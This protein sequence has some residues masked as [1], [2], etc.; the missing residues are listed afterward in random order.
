MTFISTAVAAVPTAP[1]Q[2][3]F[4]GDLTPVPS[5]SG[6][7]LTVSPACPAD[8]CNATTG[9]GTTGTDGYWEWTSTAGNG[10]GF[11]LDTEDSLTTTYTIFLKFTFDDYSG[12][13]KII[14]Y[15]NRSADTGFYMYDDKINFYDLGTSTSS[16]TTGEPL[17]LMVTRSS[18]GGNAGVF[19]V[20][21]YNGT[22]FTKE[23]EVTDNDGQS[24][25]AV[26]TVHPG[27][28]HLGFFYDD[29]NGEGTPSGKVW[30]L[31]IWPGVALNQSD[32]EAQATGAVDEP[33]PTEEEQVDL[34]D[35]GYDAATALL[36]SISL[37]IAGGV[38]ILVSRST[39]NN[40]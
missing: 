7:T 17:T 29:G 22:T 1:I 25:P 2:Y 18:T 16:F 14:D 32:L 34:A 36:L 31:K 10:G 6:S 30:D 27:G 23:L 40:K 24:I 11:E 37:A 3:H 33:T 39:K 35:T 8:P 15:L 4:E 20:Y 26:S 21:S 28:T 38:L 9:F 19:T 12:Y 13:N 5:V